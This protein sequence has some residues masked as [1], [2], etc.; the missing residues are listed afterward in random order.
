MRQIALIVILAQMGSFVPARRARIGVVDRVLTR[1]GASDNLARGESTFMVEMKE[2]ANVLRAAT[3]RSLVVLDEIG[4]GTSTYDGLAIAWAVAEHLHDAIACRAMF[5]THYH[6]LTELR[7]TRAGTARTGASPRA[8]TRATSSSSTSCSAGRRR[9]ATASRARA[10]P[11]LPEPVLARARAMLGRPRDGARRSRAA[12]TRRSAVA[13]ARGRPQLDLFDGGPGQTARRDRLA[14]IPPEPAALETLRAV[15]VDRLTPLEALH[16]SPRSSS[17]CRTSRPRPELHVSDTSRA[18]AP[19]D[20]NRSAPAIGYALVATA[21][22]AWGTWPLVLRTAERI[23]PMSPA[24]ES[25]VLMLVMAVVTGPLALRDRVAQKATVPEWLGIAWLGVADALNAFFFFEAYQ[26]TS[27]AVAVLTHY[28]APLLVALGAPVLLRE[29]PT[30][31]RVL[32][33]GGSVSP[34]SSSSSSRGDPARDPPTSPARRSA[35]RA[36]CS[37]PR[38]CSSPSGSTRTFSGSE[39]MFYHCFVA[40]PLLALMVP[41]SEWGAIN[42][43]AVGAVA[44]GSLGPGALAGLFFVWGLRRVAASRASTLTLL[45]PLVAVL[46]GALAYGETVGV[47]GIA[48]GAFILLGA[49]LVVGQGRPRK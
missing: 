3:R 15:D 46:V 21:A 12:R 28:L 26:R 18:Q 34:G 5:A 35:R 30:A 14:T 24:L 33:R 6:E 43:R 23:A 47:S 36:R 45:E 49:G 17:H 2:T 31:A 8:S 10:S 38:T 4:R 39:Q 48:G 19:H 41:R 40:C 16:S 44:L 11:G 32:R 22:C 37:T 25:S 42:L 9:E 29:R 1:V 7:R 13:R 27:V 20:S